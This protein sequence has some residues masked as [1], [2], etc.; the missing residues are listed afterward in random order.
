M[1]LT[2]I[3]TSRLS[4]MNKRETIA[5]SNNAKA[6]LDNPAW[7]ILTRKMMA[8]LKNEWTECTDPV[9]RES[10]WQTQNSLSE[11]IGEFEAAILNGNIASNP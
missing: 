10:L 5:L 9:T 1:S 8:G 6:I 7:D 4:A 3:E 2:E 11:L